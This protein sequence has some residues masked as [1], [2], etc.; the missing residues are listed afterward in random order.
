MASYG[1]SLENRWL[2]SKVKNPQHYS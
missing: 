2:K 1:D